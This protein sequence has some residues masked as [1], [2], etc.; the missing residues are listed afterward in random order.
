[1]YLRRRPPAGRME[2]LELIEVK[3][4]DIFISYREKGVNELLPL[5]SNFLARSY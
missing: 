3:R 5:S 2:S 1:M 4:S